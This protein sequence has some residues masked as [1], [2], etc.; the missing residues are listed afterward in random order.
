MII[1]GAILT[2]AAYIGESYAI[3][4][5]H[6]V[7]IGAVALGALA[8]G[9]SLIGVAFS[10]GKKLKMEV[11]GKVLG[12]DKAPGL[13]AYVQGLAEKLG[14]QPPRNIIVGLEPTFYVTNSDI[15]IPGQNEGVAGET[16]FISAPLARVFSQDEFAS[17]IGHELGHFRGEDTVYSMKFA[18]VYAG[19]G[20][21]I[22]A[23]ASDEEGGAAGLA[24]LPALSIP[25]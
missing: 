21:S 8:G 19:L 2:Y 24:K 4:R 12:P 25:G 3:G 10:F 20:Q 11:F 18:P 13:H 6:I 23:L 7:I 9:V 15:H 17:V 14:A 1:Q 16:L 22:G 5:V